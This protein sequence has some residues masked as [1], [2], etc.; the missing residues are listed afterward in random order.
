MKKIKLLLQSSPVIITA[1]YLCI[2]TLWILYSDRIV[3]SIFVEPE[4]ITRI[5]SIKGFGYVG[6]S[7]LLVFSLVWKNNRMFGEAIEK[8]N[9]YQFELQ[10]SLT[11][12]NLLLKEIHHRVKNNLAVISNLI[13]FEEINTVQREGNKVLQNTRLRIKSMA[14]IH[15]FMYQSESLTHVIFDNFVD[16]I[17]SHLKK[18]YPKN[19]NRINFVGTVDPITLNIN[20]AIPCGL[21][22]NELV[23]NAWNH[24]YPHNEKG[25]ISIKLTMKDELV[26]LNVSDDGI[27]LPNKIDPSTAESTGF[28]VIKQLCNQ[29]K[30]NTLT[31]RKNGTK[32]KITFKKSDLKGS[33]NALNYST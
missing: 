1:I 5:Q 9:R 30:A 13:Q 10:E 22:I 32:I 28:S 29:L 23:T 15:E 31:T 11:E 14:L 2:G 19:S 8:L 3:L 33:S 4:S 12:K 21:I 24:A 27:G 26:S 17:T 20:Q 18:D 6:L 16:S 25:T 7:G